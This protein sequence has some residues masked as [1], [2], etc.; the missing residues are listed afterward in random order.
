MLQGRVL[1]TGASG[2][3]GGRLLQSLREQG[4]DALGLYRQL[5]AG[6][7]QV[8]RQGDLC[9]PAS[10]LQAC[11][12]IAAIVHCAGHAH[13]FG[14]TPGQAELQHQQINLQGTLNLLAA[15]LQKG[16]QRF[17]FLSSVKAMAHP[18]DQ[19]AD[20]TFPGEPDSAYGR[21]KRAAEQ[22]VL[23]A[24]AQGMQVTNLRLA[25]TYGAGGHGNLERMAR[26]ILAGWFPPLPETGNKRSMVHVADVV[27]AIETVLQHPAAVSRTFI[28]SHPQPSSGA[29]LYDMLRRLAGRPPVRWRV[30]ARVLW[31][32]AWVADGLA[33]VLR[34][35]LPVGRAVVE[36]LLGSECYSSAELTRITGWQARVG[37]E[38]G[39][40]ELLGTN[41]PLHVQECA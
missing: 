17:V 19:V 37:L 33:A 40:R 16:V 7:G 31:G 27:A 34:R 6:S 39:L 25:M 36:R 12:G 30:P 10:L 38:A 20:E 5:P 26:G 8:A 1:V 11:E 35:P 4:C 29:E 15:A 28:V 2:F 9:D 32:V 13:A 18:H 3:I 23:D 21:A 22:A 41:R 24:A 14:E